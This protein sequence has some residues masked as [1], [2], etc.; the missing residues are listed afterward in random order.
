MARLETFG[1]GLWSTRAHDFELENILDL[2]DRAGNLV[3]NDK[4]GTGALD[5]WCFRTNVFWRF[6]CLSERLLEDDACRIAEI[7]ACICGTRMLMRLWSAFCGL[8]QDCPKHRLMSGV[9][10]E[11]A[12]RV[13]LGL[14]PVQQTCRTLTH[15][16]FMLKHGDVPSSGMVR[17]SNEFSGMLLLMCWYSFK[18]VVR[19]G[20]EIE[21]MH[22]YVIISVLVAGSG[23][24]VV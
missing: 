4:S 18:G 23:V 3:S 7:E 12:L 14:Y 22:Q 13:R 16:T 15:S 5:S 19:Y 2:P 24:K 1:V 20:T 6:G 17:S 21:R 11:E 10:Q 9:S 8:G